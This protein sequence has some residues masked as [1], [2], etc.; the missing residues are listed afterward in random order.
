MQDDGNVKVRDERTKT[1]VIPL[2]KRHPE[3][4]RNRKG[5]VPT[6]V[7][8]TKKEDSDPCSEVMLFISS[9]LA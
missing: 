3:I 1:L 8:M 7:G 4:A 6:F 2:A 5:W 9:P